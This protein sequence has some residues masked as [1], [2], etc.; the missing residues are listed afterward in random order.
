MSELYEIVQWPDV[1]D[2]ILVIVLEGWGGAGPAHPDDATVDVGDQRGAGV[3]DRTDGGHARRARRHPAGDRAPVRR[4]GAAERGA[5]G[6]GAALRGGDAVP[7]R[8]RRPARGAR[9]A[10]RR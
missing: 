3:E 6:P 10:G 4:R 7:G 9:A 8:R 1:T 2:P 5:V